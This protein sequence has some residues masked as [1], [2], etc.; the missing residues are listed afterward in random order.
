MSSIGDHVRA[1]ILT[2]ILAWLAGV[3]ALVLICAFIYEKAIE[4][5]RTIEQ[6]RVQ[7]NDPKT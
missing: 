3:V 7:G 4:H 1:V 6:S 5:G 2:F